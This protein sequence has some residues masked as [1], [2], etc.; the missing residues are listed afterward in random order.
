VYSEEWVFQQRISLLWARKLCV[1]GESCDLTACQ[2]LR[3][4]GTTP[5][6]LIVTASELARPE[7]HP[8]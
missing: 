1:C 2:P 6:S 8:L 7:F 4:P 5:D 3:T